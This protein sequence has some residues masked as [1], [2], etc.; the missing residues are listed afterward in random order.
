MAELLVVRSKVKA[1]AKKKKMRLSESAVS[2]L[3]KEVEYLIE[4]AAKR[5]KLS[6][7]GTIQDRDI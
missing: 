6:K 5:A 2:A 3:S 7:R 4:K 1:F